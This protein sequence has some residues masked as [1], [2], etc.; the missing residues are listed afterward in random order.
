M[1]KP[2]FFD[3]AS[4]RMRHSGGVVVF[5][6]RRVTPAWERH[7]LVCSL[8][9]ACETEKNFSYLALHSTA[10][11]DREPRWSNQPRVYC[12]VEG[13]ERWNENSCHFLIWLKCSQE[14]WRKP[15]SK[16][17]REKAAKEQGGVNRLVSLQVNR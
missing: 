1:A 7:L 9:I 2:S 6:S 13:K 4:V 10:G 5:L 3:R 11:T 17:S 14:C 12:G 15:I 8:S 16:T